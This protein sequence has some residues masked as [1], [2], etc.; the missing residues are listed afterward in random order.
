M[1]PSTN[2]NILSNIVFPNKKENFA[3]YKFMQKV[4]SFKV[5]NYSNS[6]RNLPVFPSMD[7]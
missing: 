7:E 1:A 2:F 5:F 4:L 6:I 3:Q